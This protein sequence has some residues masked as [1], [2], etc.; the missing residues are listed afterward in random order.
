[1]QTLLPN[2]RFTRGVIRK[3]LEAVH[4]ITLH[5]EPAIAQVAALLI[6][7]LETGREGLAEEMARACAEVVREEESHEG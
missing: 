6:H 3:R 4:A 2:R 1:M 7:A 5:H